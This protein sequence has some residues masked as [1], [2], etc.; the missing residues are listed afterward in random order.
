VIFFIIITL[1]TISCELSSSSPKQTDTTPPANVTSFKASTNSMGVALGFANIILE[2]EDP[3]DN[4]LAHVKIQVVPDTGAVLEIPSGNQT[5]TLHNV[6]NERTYTFTVSTVD[7]AGNASDIFVYAIGTSAHGREV[8]NMTAVAGNGSAELSWDDPNFEGFTGIRISY[9]A[10][11]NVPIQMQTGDEEIIT[12]D[13]AL[14]VGNAAIESLINGRPY[15]FHFQSL[16]VSGYISPGVSVGCQPMAPPKPLP[17]GIT[18]TKENGLLTNEIKDV[19]VTEDGTVALATNYGVSI[20]DGFSWKHYTENDGL[21][22]RFIHS[23]YID[24]AGVIYAAT[25]SDG[26]GVY[27]G[28]SWQKYGQELFNKEMRGAYGDTDG[29]VYFGTQIKGVYRF[30]DNIFTAIS[31][32]QGP[33]NVEDLFVDNAGNFYVAAWSLYLYNGNEWERFKIS[34]GFSH[35]VC[36]FALSPNR[37]VLGSA[38]D[39][40]CVYDGVQWITYTTE[41]GLPSNGVQ[42]VWMDEDGTI[43]AGTA[44]GLGYYDGSSWTHYKSADWTDNNRINSVVQDEAGTLYIATNE[45][46]TVVKLE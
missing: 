21:P 39:G 29:N 34:G 19:F 43:I 37:I 16:D 36:V 46:L 10:D 9:Y 28:A 44:R 27:D 45:G 41:Q 42:S 2:W 31:G 25:N 3:P 11:G 17:A 5:V 40:L 1:N 22:R 32:I 18:Y 12:I 7:K 15:I 35:I 33:A 14:G 6:P 38:G 23:V 13:F 30:K 26:I 20:Y 24:A 4:D 8:G